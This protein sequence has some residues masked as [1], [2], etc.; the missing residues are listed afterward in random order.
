M[1]LNPSTS[2]SPVGVQQQKTRLST[3]LD[4]LIWLGDELVGQQPGVGNL[5]L[6]E[7]RTDMLFEL[8]LVL[9][10]RRVDRDVGQ[11]GRGLDELGSCCGFGGGRGDGDA[12]EPVGKQQ[13]SVVFANSFGRH[14][15]LYNRD[16][17]R[18]KD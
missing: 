15:L 16:K 17:R 3:T 12:V 11:T 13:L 5:E 8:G 2:I 6:V 9:Q 18:G 14:D 7:G 10:K 1:L 4:Q